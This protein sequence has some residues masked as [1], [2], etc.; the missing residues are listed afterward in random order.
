[1][2]RARSLVAVLSCVVGLG[3]LGGCGGT[4]DGAGSE[5]QPEPADVVAAGEAAA[6]LEEEDDASSPSL[7]PGAEPSGPG[8]VVEE[9]DGRE[10]TLASYGFF[11][12]D[13]DGQALPGAPLVKRLAVFGRT[14]MPEDEP[15]VGV[16]GAS[17]A[18]PSDAV[19]VSAGEEPVSPEELAGRLLEGESRRVASNVPAYGADLYVVPSREGWACQFLVS[20]RVETGLCTPGLGADGISWIPHL[21]SRRLLLQGFAGNEVVAINVVVDRREESAQLAGNAFYYTRE[22]SF[23][24]LPLLE[25]FV[26][27]DTDGTTRRVEIPAIPVPPP[28][29]PEAPTPPPQVLLEPEDPARPAPGPAPAPEPPARPAPASTSPPGRGLLYGRKVVGRA[30]EIWLLEPESGERRQLTDQAEAED[31]DSDD[32]G[33]VWSPDGRLIAFA[34]SRDYPS[35]PSW[36]IYVMNA[37]GSGQRRLTHDGRATGI[38]RWTPD[39]EWI[40]YARAPAKPPPTQA[41]AFRFE[42]VAIRPDGSDEQLLIEFDTPLL[43]FDWSP[44]GTR[45]AL[46][47]CSFDEQFDCEISIAG[48]DGT[49]QVTVADSAGS[50][51]GP[52]WSPDGTRIA[53]I[54]TRDENGRCFFHECTGYNGE[55]YVMNADG[56]GHTRLTDSPGQDLAPTWSPDGTR[57]AF[58]NLPSQDGNN[59]IHT[60]SPN[61]E[62]LEQLTNDD[63]WSISSDWR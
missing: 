62:G 51:Y 49:N 4:V 15:P 7:S 42:L 1:M 33:P 19:T 25:A 63:A 59:D 52:V 24:L 13:G 14:R 5:A 39:G 20:D 10:R 50:D 29:P 30:S 37:D 6:T 8:L 40:T 2:V 57:I 54:S 32:N 43:G 9:P 41:D 56:T 21:T 45:L 12:S 26:L 16:R 34:S 35:D 31:L 55:I 11:V 22:G 38:V 23:E 53:F 36:E 27:T 47:L 58:S 3:A 48:P 60:V 17:F 44:D 46:S 28:A 18:V 61:G